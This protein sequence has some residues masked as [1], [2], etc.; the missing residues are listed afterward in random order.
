MVIELLYA[1]LYY[2]LLTGYGPMTEAHAESVARA[3][4]SGVTERSGAAP[5][6]TYN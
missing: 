3:M 2:R 4:L 1:P 6:P 5:D